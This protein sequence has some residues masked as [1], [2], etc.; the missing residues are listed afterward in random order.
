MKKLLFALTLVLCLAISMVAFTSCGGNGEGEGEGEG[1]GDACVHTWAA[2]PTTDKAATCTEEG[3]ESVKCVACGEKKADSVTAIPATGYA[4]DA[5]LTAVSA[6][7][8]A[9]EAKL[10]AY[11]A[12]Y[13]SKIMAVKL[14]TKNAELKNAL[15]KPILAKAEDYSIDQAKAIVDAYVVDL[16]GKEASV[17]NGY[18]FADSRIMQA[19]K[20]NILNNYDTIVLG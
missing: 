9:Y 11:L 8:A 1:T 18:K 16:C 13:T 12:D 20:L 10:N 7:G 2:N 5:G 14:E 17:W 15:D 4:Y 19:Y 3:S 6:K